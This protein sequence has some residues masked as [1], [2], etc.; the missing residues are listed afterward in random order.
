MSLPD[1]KCAATA[2][3]NSVTIVYSFDTSSVSTTLGGLTMAVQKLLR[4]PILGMLFLSC[5]FGDN[6]CPSAP[7]SRSKEHSWITCPKDFVKDSDTVA[8][9]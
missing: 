8:L 3:L 1:A 6:T 2:V 7:I 4:E 5:E 9:D